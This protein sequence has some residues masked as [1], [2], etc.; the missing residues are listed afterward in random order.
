MLE[1][2]RIVVF[3]DGQHAIFNGEGYSTWHESTL[4]T[5]AITQAQ[6]LD[7]YI[8]PFALLDAIKRINDELDQLYGRVNDSHSYRSRSQYRR[9]Y[10][11]R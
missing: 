11:H 3:G 2:V 5:A 7:H 9:G 4:L 8:S 1:K 10:S 6:E